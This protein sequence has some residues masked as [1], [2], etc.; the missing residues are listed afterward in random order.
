MNPLAWRQEHQVAII[1][2]AILGAVIVV[3]IGF[4]YRGLNFGTITSALFWS[5]STIRWTIL[6]ALIGAGIVYVRRLLQT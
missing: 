3:V 1:L 2:G 5:A 6:G 4:I